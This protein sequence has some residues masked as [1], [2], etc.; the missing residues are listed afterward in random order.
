M[1]T[2]IAVVAVGLIY[3]GIMLFSGGGISTGDMPS[4]LTAAPAATTPPPSTPSGRQS[5]TL[6]GGGGTAPPTAAG[7]PAPGGGAPAP[8]SPSGGSA[9]AG[10]N[11]ANMSEKDKMSALKGFE[12]VD[13]H[14]IMMKRQEES[15]NSETKV[16]AENDV[17]YPDTGRTDPLFIVSEAIPEELRPPRTGETDYDSILDF[18]ITAQGSAMLDAVQIEVWSVMQIG[19]EKFV[20]MSVDGALMTVQEGGGGGTPSGVSFSVASATQ[21][22]VII[23]L[24]VSTQYTSVSKTKSFIPKE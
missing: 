11:V 12:K 15:K 22:E 9:P 6:T 4:S 18:I 1:I 3:G 5:F 19:M 7:A 14:D 20:N 17:P 16:D 2:L 8:G 10:P 13:S 23:V 24:S 21:Q